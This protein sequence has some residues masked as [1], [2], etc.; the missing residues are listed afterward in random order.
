[1]QHGVDEA[2]RPGGADD[3]LE[4]DVEISQLLGWHTEERGHRLGTQPQPPARP[5]GGEPVQH[6]PVGEPDRHTSAKAHDHVGAPVGHNPLVTL[7]GRPLFPEAR[8]H[9]APGRRRVPLAIGVRFVQDTAQCGLDTDPMDLHVDIVTLAVP[10]LE[11]AHRYY[12]DRLGWKPA[13]AVPGTVTFL[14]AG[15]GRMV[16]LFSRGDLAT[17]IGSGDAPP[18]DL[19]HLCEDEAGVDAVTAALLDAGGTVRKPPQRAEWGGYHAYV[20]APDGTVWEI[21]HN[22]GWSVD[23]DGTAH[24]GPV[25]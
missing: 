15:A 10:D 7:D 18:F 25:S 21:A 22:P 13:L 23:A 14:N 4:R 5:P 6:R 20:E 9:A 8:D 19:G 2:T 16:A 1:V 24:I 12:V 17:D 11:A 3:V